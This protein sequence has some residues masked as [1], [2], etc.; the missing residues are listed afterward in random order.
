MALPTIAINSGTGSDTLSSGAGPSTALNGSL[1]ATH[2]NTTVNITDAVNLGGVAVDGS[3]VL[4]VSSSSGKQWAKITNIT[5]SSGA[6]VVT[7][8]D[9]YANTESTRN[10]AIG[11]K[12]AT[13]AGSIQLG[14]DCK[15]GWII[16]VQDNQTLTANFAL[17]CNAVANS[18]TKFTSTTTTRP[19][20][21][22]STNAIYGLVVNNANNLVISHLSF[23]ST[24]GTPGNGISPPAS[25]AGGSSY[26]DITDCIIDGFAYGIRDS[27]N[28]GNVAIQG[29][30]ISSCEIK[31][32]TLIG[33]VTWLGCQLSNTFIHNCT[34]RGLQVISTFQRAANISHCI[35]DS[36]GTANCE[37]GLNTNCSTMVNYCVF[38]NAVTVSSNGIGLRI[39]TG[40]PITVTVENC[41]FW[42]NTTY[43]MATD[44][45]GNL[46]GLV[47]HNNAWG[48]NS[49]ANVLTPIPDTG[50]N[51]VTLTANPFVSSSD[52]GLNTTAGGGNSCRN[53]AYTI[54]NASANP[55]PDIGAVPSGGGAVTVAGATSFAY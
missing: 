45:G 30:A 49:T 41:I 52:F 31:N 20:I 50:I 13:L 12:R 8:S 40:N 24:A 26:V 6:W 25:G 18:W 2:T 34:G 54:P 23:K 36:N 11:G 15:G 51:A 7:V 1:A 35:F 33:I 19:I 29:L 21:S 42:G 37:I 47:M 39:G 14:L 48:S 28:G 10:W 32:C 5:G 16:D 17:N 3:A 4:W 46:D 53:A 38:S 44:A 22:T 55:A 9:A 43:G 27:D